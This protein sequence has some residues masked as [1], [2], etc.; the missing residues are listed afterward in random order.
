MK[1]KGLL[2]LA[3]ILFIYSCNQTNTQQ[4]TTTKTDT[5]VEDKKT[6]ET[7]TPT[8]SVE[9]S[10][11]PSP[12][13]SSTPTPSVSLAPLIDNYRLT[14]DGK[15]LEGSKNVIYNKI[16]DPSGGSEGRIQIAS[17]GY[18]TVKDGDYTYSFRLT[19]MPGN[20]NILPL[21]FN[22]NDFAMVLLEVKKEGKG[23]LFNYKANLLTGNKEIPLDKNGNNSNLKG[24]KSNVMFES[25][26]NDNSTKRYKGTIESPLVAEANDP[27]LNVKLEWN[28]VL[29]K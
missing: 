26:D 20:M 22:Q 14:I 15:V 4:T 24:I 17:M 13:V 25:L 21:K 10:K 19:I 27:V 28:Y 8:P 5:K 11:E 2:V 3:S 16:D 9:A 6:N 12:I 7:S 18:E 23:K 29:K 1:T